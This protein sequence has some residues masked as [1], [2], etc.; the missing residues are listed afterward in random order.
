[1]KLCSETSRFRNF[2]RRFIKNKVD[3]IFFILIWMKFG[4]TTLDGSRNFLDEISCVLL[5][6]GINFV[7]FRGRA[8]R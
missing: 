2:G 6:D 3:E 4:K 7:C 1:M 8:R 5:L